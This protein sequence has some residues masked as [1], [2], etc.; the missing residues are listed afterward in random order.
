MI[1]IPDKRLPKPL[2]LEEDRLRR[3]TSKTTWKRHWKLWI[4]STLLSG[5]QQHWTNNLSG[6][7]SR[8]QL[9]KHQK[10]NNHRSIGKQGTQ[11]LSSLDQLQR[12]LSL[13][14]LPPVGVPSES[15]SVPAVTLGPTETDHEME[16]EVMVII[17]CWWTN[18]I[19]VLNPLA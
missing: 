6:Q 7:K 13:T 18:T 16:T 3:N 10:P 8:Q 4:W 12:L 5:S 15:R 9:A 17:T 14:H 1:R 19:L 2:L 11:S